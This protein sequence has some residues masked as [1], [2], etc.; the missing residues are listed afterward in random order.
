M[1]DPLNKSLI[2]N[3]IDLFNLNS[4]L[5]PFPTHIIKMI[6]DCNISKNK[7]NYFENGN[8]KWNPHNLSILNLVI[9]ISNNFIRLNHSFLIIID[10]SL[11]LTTI[12][13]VCSILR[14]ILNILFYYKHTEKTKKV[15]YER[16]Q[17]EN[18]I[19]DSPC[20]HMWIEY[21]V[22]RRLSLGISDKIIPF[23]F[24]MTFHSES[25]PH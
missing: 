22:L 7:I 25:I 3:S 18:H 9:I 20:R 17:R 2:F 10:A 24:I 23:I 21:P 5:F 13:I 8:Y 19:S 1:G 15:E 16:K 6:A 4:T 14:K 11:T 12:I